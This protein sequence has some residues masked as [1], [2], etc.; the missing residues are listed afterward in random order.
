MFDC[1][2]T[3]SKNL[4]QPG[5]QRAIVLC[6]CQPIGRLDLAIR[7]L[8]ATGRAV[9]HERSDRRAAYRTANDVAI[10]RVPEHLRAPFA[11][12]WNEIVERSLANGTAT[13]GKDGRIKVRRV[14]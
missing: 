7:L 8:N 13:R 3:A 1:R 5:G 12:N 11:A 10:L 6:A 14:E 9:Q 2:L 4:A